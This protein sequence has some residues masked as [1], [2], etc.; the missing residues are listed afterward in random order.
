MHFISYYY[1]PITIIGTKLPHFARFTC[2]SIFVLMLDFL[3]LAFNMLNGRHLEN[4]Q[5]IFLKFCS[6]LGLGDGKIIYSHSHC[7]TVT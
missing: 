3:N 4:R 1:H 6:Y 5:H 7:I 2:V